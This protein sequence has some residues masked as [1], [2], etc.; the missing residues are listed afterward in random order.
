VLTEEGR[1]QARGNGEREGKKM[2]CS[3]SV[4]TFGTSHVATGNWVM[5]LTTHVIPASAS[6][7]SLS[8]LLHRGGLAESKH[9]H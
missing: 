7:P 1:N 4:R 2:P 5:L 8:S 6:L 3:S 9:P